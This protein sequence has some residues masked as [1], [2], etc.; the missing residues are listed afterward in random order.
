[1]NGET[2]R[3]V[4][5]APHYLV[6]S[7]GRVMVVPYEAPMPHGGTRQYGGEPTVGAWCA[8]DERYTT[9]YKGKTYR[10]APLVCEAFHGPK[11]T[12]DAV[13]MHL[14][15][16]SRNNRPSNLQWGTQQQNLN[17][18]KYLAALSERVRKIC[19]ASAQRIRERYAAGEL[20]KAIAADFGIAHQTVSGIVRG[21]RKCDMEFR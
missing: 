7:E 12:P 19:P 21:S 20:Q 11:P 14:D 3:N 6:S 15:E 18:P 10:V 13:C 16:D 5:S 1:M 4:P 8:E 2:W 9:T 17:A